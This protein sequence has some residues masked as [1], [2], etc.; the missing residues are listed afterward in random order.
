[1]CPIGGM[2]VK[3]YWSYSH[4]NDWLFKWLNSKHMNRPPGC[5]TRYASSITYKSKW[6]IVHYV[7]INRP[8]TLSMCVQLRMPNAIV[9]ALNEFASNG[10]FSAF[11]HTQ[12]M[13]QLLSDSL[14]NWNCSAR[15]LPTSN[16]FWLIS[17]TVT[18]LHL[19]LREREFRRYLRYRKA[20]SPVPPAISSN[21]VPCVGPRRSMKISFQTRWMPSDIASFIKSYD[22]ATSSNTLCT[23][24]KQNLFQMYRVIERK[25]TSPYLCPPFHFRALFENRTMRSVHLMHFLWPNNSVES[26]PY[27]LLG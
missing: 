16:M 25:T 21:R 19:S 14:V 18:W 13:V 27:Q 2:H 22:A 9:Y 23:A 10:S 3:E 6:I 17:D 20:M 24:D 26:H 5:K 8:S 7:C 15:F 1:M 12:S 11:A 4:C